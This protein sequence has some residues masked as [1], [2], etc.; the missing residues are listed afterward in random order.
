MQ[1]KE[2]KP[3]RRQPRRP[4]TENLPTTKLKGNR[5]LKVRRLSPFLNPSTIAPASMPH[6]ATRTRHAAKLAKRMRAPEHVIRVHLE[7]AGM[8]VEGDGW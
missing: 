1:P 5:V 8:G 2:E 3:T 4:R 6:P 7:A